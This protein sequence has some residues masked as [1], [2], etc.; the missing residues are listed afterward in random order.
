MPQLAPETLNGFTTDAHVFTPVDIRQGTS[1][2]AENL[3]VGAN[4]LTQSIL[5]RG[6]GGIRSKRH[7][8]VPIVRVDA[9]GKSSIIGY[10]Y[11][12]VDF[13]IHPLSTAAEKELTVGLSANAAKQAAFQTA[14]VAGQNYY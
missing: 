12:K 8:E 13:S 10:N 2:L 6:D 4:K 11:G 3:A 9:S 7:I 14:T 1:V 5:P